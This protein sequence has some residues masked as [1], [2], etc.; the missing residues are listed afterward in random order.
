MKL[1]LQLME[2]S[3]DFEKIQLS[4]SGLRTW[5]QGLVPDLFSPTETEWLPHV[6]SF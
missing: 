6:Y 3:L 5:G 2:S 1:D 4:Q